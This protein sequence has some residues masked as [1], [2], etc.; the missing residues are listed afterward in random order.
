MA[1]VIAVLN[2]K[3]GSGKTT[4]AIHIA[5]ALQ[6]GGESVAL[7]DTD[8]QGSAQDWDAAGEGA[9]GFLV[10]GVRKPETLKKNVEQLA[11][12]HWIIIDGAGSLDT[13]SAHAVR[14]A[15]LVVIP[16]QPSPLDVWA[17]SEVVA[18]VTERQALTDGAPVAAF[19]VMRAKKGTQLAREVTDAIAEYGFPL[20]NG[21]IH[22]RTAF[23]KAMAAGKTV[24][25]TDPEGAAC[26]EVQH[27]IKQIREAFA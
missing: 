16:C 21:S 19:Q 2:Q 8:P 3:G 18:M 10:V 27:L 22:D 20:F 9:A 25:D 1:N 26:W 4:V 14:A 11:S 17:A 13:M 12:H 6:L 24:L 23:A 5:R 15:D 7:L